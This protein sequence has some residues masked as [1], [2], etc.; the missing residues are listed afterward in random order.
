MQ[1]RQI[2]QE[3]R[4]FDR[5][6]R[7]VIGIGLNLQADVAVYGLIGLLEIGVVKSGE[8]IVDPPEAGQAGFA[9]QTV[10]GRVHAQDISMYIREHETKIEIGQEGFADFFSVGVVGFNVIQQEGRLIGDPDAAAVLIGYHNGFARDQF[11]VDEAAVL[12]ERHIAAVAYGL[13]YMIELQAKG[14][15]LIELAGVNDSAGF[16][17]G[18]AQNDVIIV[19]IILQQIVEQIPDTLI[20]V[21]NW[22]TIN[23]FCV[24]NDPPCLFPALLYYTKNTKLV[25]DFAK[26]F[27]MYSH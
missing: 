2:E 24:H 25:K 3:Q 7:L 15:L 20:K 5:F 17:P 8:D 22:N 27:G 1:I 10:G 19:N 6:V 16:S 14:N 26:C 12:R 21:K 23:V 13:Q 4:D 18:V 9:E 11:R